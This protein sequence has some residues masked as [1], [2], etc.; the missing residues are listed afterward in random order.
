M[1]IISDTGPIIG[2]AKIDLLFL[3]DQIASE[4]L[5][6]PMVHRELMGKAGS[7]T[8]Q[9]DKA[10]RDFL[11]VADL[12]PLTPAVEKAISALDE[13]EREVIGLASTTSGHV[14]T[15]MDDRAGREAAAKLNIPVSGLVG[16]L[17]FAKEKGIVKKIGPL[18]LELRDKRYWLSDEVVQA[19]KILAGET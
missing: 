1:K 9:I 3:L 18:L 13:G 2:L 19:A 12:K 15:L 8:A 6:P 11:K 17:L 4:V 7:E 5:I 10:L 14:L 16:I